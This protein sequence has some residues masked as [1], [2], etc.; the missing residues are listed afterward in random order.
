VIN[1][2]S[3]RHYIILNLVN[4]SLTPSPQAFWLKQCHIHLKTYLTDQVIIIIFGLIDIGDDY[5]NM[6][7]N[8]VVLIAKQSNIFYCHRKGIVPSFNMFLAC[9]RKTV[10][11]EEFL[12]QQNNKMSLHQ[13]GLDTKIPTN[14]L[15]IFPKFL[16]K[17]SKNLWFHL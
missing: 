15:K 11:I 6:S 3:Y 13:L 5:F 17:C 8:H 9:L 7:L 4:Q 2:I 12:A 1:I 14:G 10:K 16:Q